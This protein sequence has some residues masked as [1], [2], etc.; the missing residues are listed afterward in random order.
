MLGWKN[1]RGRCGSGGNLLLYSRYK[2]NTGE[3]ICNPTETRYDTYTTAGNLGCG[4]PCSWSISG[5]PAGYVIDKAFVWALV[6]YKSN[7]APNTTVIITNPATNTN[8][9]SASP[10]GTDASVCWGE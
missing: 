4:L 8:N 7:T 1:K 2:R 9:Y 10:I 3:G 6:S 5:L